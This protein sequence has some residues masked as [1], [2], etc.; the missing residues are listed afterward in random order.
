V[1]LS[2]F[3]KFLFL[4]GRF[5]TARSS[6]PDERD[7]LRTKLAICTLQSRVLFFFGRG[8]SAFNCAFPP[9]FRPFT[10]SMG[11]RA[12]A[13]VFG[14]QDVYHFCSFLLPSFHGHRTLP[15]PCP[16][17]LWSPILTRPPLFVPLFRPD[18]SLAHSLAITTLRSSRRAFNLSVAR[19]PLLF[20]SLSSRLRSALD[21][22]P[23]VLAFRLS[24]SSVHL[25]CC[26][27]S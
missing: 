3:R 27:L 12:G 9:L 23:R 26:R 5:S 20:P 7:R 22:C 4:A 6:D 8:D 10:S 1:S 25:F 15:L 16:P 2:P 11:F 14:F 21:G 17:R 19:F 18:P 24:I 13:S